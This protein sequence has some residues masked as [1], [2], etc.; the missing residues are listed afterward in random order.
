MVNIPPDLLTTKKQKHKENIFI[1][2]NHS[3][4]QQHAVVYE[5]KYSVSWC[6]GAL[7]VKSPPRRINILFNI[8]STAINSMLI[9]SPLKRGPFQTTVC[10]PKA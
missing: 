3:L 10:T 2:H 6:L 8:V 9:A 4:Y 7:V 5:G 1:F